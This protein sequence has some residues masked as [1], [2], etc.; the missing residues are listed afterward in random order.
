MAIKKAGAK[1]HRPFKHHSSHQCQY[2]RGQK[3]PSDFGSRERSLGVL[4]SNA[5][6]RYIVEHYLPFKASGDGSS[7][8]FVFI[9]RLVEFLWEPEEQPFRPTDVAEPIRVRIA[10]LCL[11]RGRRVSGSPRHTPRVRR[12]TASRDDIVDIARSLAR[13]GR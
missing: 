5:D 12:P 8:R 3:F 7:S 11:P 9:C 4:T 10:G 6:D 1:S 2:I 13:P